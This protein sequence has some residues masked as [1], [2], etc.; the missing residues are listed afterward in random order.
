M[1]FFNDEDEENIF[2][3]NNGRDLYKILSETCE[4]R[5]FYLT[6]FDTKYLL[7]FNRYG[8]LYGVGAA[9]DWVSKMFRRG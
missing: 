2:V 1:L 5:E 7:S 3:I 4:N 9:K 8:C 6:D